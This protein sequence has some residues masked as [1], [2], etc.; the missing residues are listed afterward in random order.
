MADPQKA[1]KLAATEHG[2]VSL[3]VWSSA[4][5]SALHILSLSAGSAHFVV[6]LKSNQALREMRDFIAAHRGHPKSEWLEVGIFASCAVG[7]YTGRDG[8]SLI[9]DGHESAVFPESFGIRFAGSQLDSLCRAL[10]DI[11]QAVYH[12]PQE[13]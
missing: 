9:C 1:S 5:E 8:V 3:H 12:A 2:D 11:I 4:T 10:D 13:A 7:V 6:T